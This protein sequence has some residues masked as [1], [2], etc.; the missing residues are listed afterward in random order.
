MLRAELWVHRNRT[1]RGVV[2]L[3]IKPQQQDLEL[4]FWVWGAQHEDAVVVAAAA[5]VQQ[6]LA[7]GADCAASLNTGMFSRE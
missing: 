6:A 1:F 3:V 4:E 5:G 7:L 2:V